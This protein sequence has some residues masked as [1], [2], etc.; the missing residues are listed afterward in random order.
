MQDKMCCIP[1]FLKHDLCF[2]KNWFKRFG[3]QVSR[4]YF[5][6]NMTDQDIFQNTRNICTYSLA[7]FFTV[8]LACLTC[9]V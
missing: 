2:S 8:D 4:I 1:A 7:T 5:G 3:A 9:I 6:I